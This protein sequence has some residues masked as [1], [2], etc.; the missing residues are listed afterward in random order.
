MK[1]IGLIA[2]STLLLGACGSQ[3]NIVDIPIIFDDQRIE[4]TEEYMAQR[5]GLENDSTQIVPKMVVLHWTSIP[6]LEKSFQAFN[7][8][9]LPTWRPDL[10]NVSGLNVSSHF[11][12]DRDGT[13]YR[14]MPETTMARHTIG[15]NHCA[16]GIENV[17]GGEKLPLTKKQVKANIFLVEYLASKYDIEYVIGHQEYTQFEGHPLWLEVDDGYRTTKTDPGMDFMEKVRKATKKYNF[18]PVPKS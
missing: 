18:K 4:L 14:L 15:L 9:T 8:S 6:S 7:R 3:K 10:E 2:L 12:V 5:Y 16:I 17:G 1:K 13:I 11:L